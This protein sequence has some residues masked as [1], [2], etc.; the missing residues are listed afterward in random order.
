MSLF[1][2]SANISG[3]TKSNAEATKMLSFVLKKKSLIILAILLYE[4]L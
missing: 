2:A 3:M 4:I 1:S